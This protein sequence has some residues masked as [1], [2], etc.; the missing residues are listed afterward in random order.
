MPCP[1]LPSLS[2]VDNDDNINSDDDNN[3]QHVVAVT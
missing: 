2:T 1:T 3:K